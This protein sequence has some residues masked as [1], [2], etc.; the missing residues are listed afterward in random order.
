MSAG[1]VTCFVVTNWPRTLVLVAVLLCSCL[2]LSLTQSIYFPAE[3]ITPN[4][5]IFVGTNSS[6]S[7]GLQ[8]L[9]NN[10][11]QRSSQLTAGAGRSWVDPNYSLTAGLLSHFYVFVSGLNIS[12]FSTSYLQIWRPFPQNNSV[13]QLVYQRL[14]Y[15]NAS[16]SQGLLYT[17]NMSGD[18]FRV[19]SGD[20]IGWTNEQDYTQISYGFIQNYSIRFYKNPVVMNSTYLFDPIQYPGVFSVAVEIDH[21]KCNKYY[22]MVL[23]NCCAINTHYFVLFYFTVLTGF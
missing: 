21:S 2:P 1:A 5:N 3:S 17:F 22:S 20:C 23:A 18:N 19:A 8:I 14:V 9:G 6:Q 12:T 10:V 15:F 7:Y 11:T 4:G 16:V 13:F